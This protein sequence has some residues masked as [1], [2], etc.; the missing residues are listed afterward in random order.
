MSRVQSVARITAL[1]VVGLGLAA[2]PALRLAHAD[3]AVAT[4]SAA[5]PAASPSWTVTGQ[6]EEACSCDGACP[7]WFNHLPTKGT[8]SG[9]MFYFI[10]KGTYGSTTLDGLAVGSMIQSVKGK[11][12]MESIGG[13]PFLYLYVDEKASPEQRQA[14]EAI[15]R[16]SF[17][18]AAAKDMKTRYVPITRTITGNE[19]K[20][21]FGTY[22]S[23][24]GHVLQGP[25]G[26]PTKIVNPPG[27]DP[28]HKEYDQGEATQLTHADAMKW[29][30]AGT[31]YMFNDF[32]VSSDEVAKF[33]A[34]MEEMMKQMQPAKPGAM[35]HGAMGSD[36]K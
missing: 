30:F 24:T 6:I 13:W 36:K 4:A 16:A 8:C 27:A 9:G 32:T 19:H 2:G 23:F 28:F 5:V 21:A 12:M 25:F 7:C 29:Q 10:D 20:I 11:T 15:M 34:Q 33:N 14:L 18:P 3:G 35:D 17:P 31:N 22:G 1:V 26:G